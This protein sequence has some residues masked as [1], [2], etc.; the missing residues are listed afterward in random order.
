MQASNIFT[1]FIRTVV[2]TIVGA[3]L[4]FLASK[5]IELDATAAANLTGF[6]TALFTA[7]YYL[8]ARII[9][10]KWPGAGKYLLGSAKQPDY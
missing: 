6:L 3:V 2:P 10:A 1:S 4:A 5:G 7:L 8:V 9:E